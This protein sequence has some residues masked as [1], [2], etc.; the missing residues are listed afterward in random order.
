MCHQQWGGALTIMWIQLD[1]MRQITVYKC[2]IRSSEIQCVCVCIWRGGGEK[3]YFTDNTDSIV[4]G[5]VECRRRCA[6]PNC[7]SDRRCAVSSHMKCSRR[8]RFDGLS[9]DVEYTGSASSVTAA[10]IAL[11]AAT[12]QPH[13]ERRHFVFARNTISHHP[14]SDSYLM[15]EVKWNVPLMFED[16]LRLLQHFL[17]SISNL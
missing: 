1:A 10:L 11:D 2:D 4:R 9:P 7:A 6:S 12:L 15:R 13:A 3:S 16:V 8:R 14:S 17:L 5:A